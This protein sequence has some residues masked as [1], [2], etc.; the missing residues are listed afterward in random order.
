MPVHDWTRIDAGIFHDFHNAWVIELRNALNSGL[1]PSSFYALTEQHA[2]RYVADLLTLHTHVPENESLPLHLD[3]GGL[4]L[5]E[6]PPKVRLKLTSAGSLRRLRRTLAIR[7]VSGHRLIALVEIVAAANKDRA[8]HVREFVAKAVA[9]VEHGVHVL[10]VDLF[11]P[12]RHDPTGMHAAIWEHFD[13]ERYVPPAD[14][15]FTLASYAAGPVPEAYV[16]H[17]TL[18]GDL[19][20][21]PLL[22]NWER[23]VKVPL[24]STYQSA[25][26]GFPAFWRDVLEGRAV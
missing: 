15:P 20:E 6:A 26:R 7:H 2:G 19:P 9:A 12:G 14:E 25:Y 21:M 22:L 1:L 18:G 8:E 16:E 10:L 11:P 4:A 24:E 17:V 23:Y 13:D 5:A 3:G